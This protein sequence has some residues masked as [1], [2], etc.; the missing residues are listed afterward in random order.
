MKSPIKI[1]CVLLG[2]ESSGKSS[3]VLRYKADTFDALAHATI[4]CAF[5]L[6]K[7]DIKQQEIYLE[8]WDT[9]G[10]ERYKSLLPM[11]YRSADV[12]LICID[13]STQIENK[14]KLDIWINEID[15]IIDISS[16]IVYIVGTKSDIGDDVCRQNLM[17]ELK[18]YPEFVYMETSA[19]D[20][21]NIS[22]LF[23]DCA[24]EIV[25][26][27]TELG[28][29]CGLYDM[30]YHMLTEKQPGCFNKCYA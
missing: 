1:K 8:I 18:K 7:F 22:R 14:S 21:M 13:L 12:V 29:Q 6:K 20:D 26:K 11:Y 3:L 2:S 17:V 4:G 10:S 19:K 5:N 24:K 28:E 9:S 16:K 30:N 27:Q 23:N 25:K 15:E